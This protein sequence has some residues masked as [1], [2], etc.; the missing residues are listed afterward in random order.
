M[1]KQTNKI[2]ILIILI[3][4][5]AFA[6]VYL[7]GDVLSLE[8]IKQYR[9]LLENT[10]REHYLFSVLTFVVVY[11]AVVALS[12]PGATVLTLAGGYLFGLAATT[13]YVN[14]AATAGATL[15]F[16]V[17]RYLLGDW[18][19]E[20]YRSQLAT[21]NREMARNGSR[22]L[23]SLRLVPAFPFFLIN[24]LAGFTKVPLGTFIWTTSLGI[25]PGSAVYA[26]AGQQLGAITAPTEILSPRVIA[27]F[28]LLALF[29]L[30]P[31]LLDAVRSRMNRSPD[32]DHRKSP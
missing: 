25:I 3:A 1:T 18:I 23:L 7:A 28:T 31:V 24:V 27:A 12:I 26:Y 29:A 19:Q 22:Y 9:A 5:V 16:L 2:L 20:K 4:A 15:A 21:F 30:F 17:A 11:I 6:R 8:N 32:E 10:V 13:L 14:V